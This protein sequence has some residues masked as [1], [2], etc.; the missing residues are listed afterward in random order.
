MI[1]KG[2]YKIRLLGKFSVQR[3]EWEIEPLPSAK[4]KGLF[5]YLLLHRDRSGSRE[6]L[7]TCGNDIDKIL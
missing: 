5:C 4:A 7:A 1:Y 2:D 3:N 6:V